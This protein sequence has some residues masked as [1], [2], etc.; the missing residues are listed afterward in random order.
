MKVG[1]LVQVIAKNGSGYGEHLV[2]CGALGVITK[3]F[4]NRR[5]K[6]DEV[7]IA[8]IGVGTPNWYYAECWKVVSLRPPGVW[9]VTQ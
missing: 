6:G 3:H 4:G 5:N 8:A 9:V 1:D 7:E 2:P